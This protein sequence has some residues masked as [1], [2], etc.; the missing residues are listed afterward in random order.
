MG[1]SV[2]REIYNHIFQ[3]EGSIGILEKP[4]TVTDELYWTTWAL[5]GIA[6][7]VGAVLLNSSFLATALLGVVFSKAYSHPAVR[8]KAYPILSWILVPV[9]QVFDIFFFNL[10]FPDLK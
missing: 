2:V 8:I 3:D 5:E 6:V 9:V 10:N 1:A 7:L 4:P